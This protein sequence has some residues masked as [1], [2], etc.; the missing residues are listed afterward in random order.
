MVFAKP[1]I[2]LTPVWSESPLKR[3]KKEP[4]P[5][6][7]KIKVKPRKPF[8]AY[9]RLAWKLT[10]QNAS[11]LKGIELRGFKSFHIDHKISIFYAFKNNISAENVAHISNLRMI[12]HKDNLDKG[13]KCHID[14]ENNWIINPDTL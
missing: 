7:E 4:K 1:K 8:K 10:E 14:E 13:M 11:N 2:D 12:F 5:V 9:K 6:I 3:K